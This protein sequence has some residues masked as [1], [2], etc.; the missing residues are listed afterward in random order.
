MARNPITFKQI[1]ELID[2]FEFSENTEI[3]IEYSP[4][5]NN[6][7]DLVMHSTYGYNNSFRLILYLTDSHKILKIEFDN[8]GVIIKRTFSQEV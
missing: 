8:E 2:E 3:R 1:K 7:D 5:I 6:S 4:V